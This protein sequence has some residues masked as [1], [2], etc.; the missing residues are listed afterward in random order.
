MEEF[1]IGIEQIGMTLVMIFVCLETYHGTHKAWLLVMPF[2]IVEI[3]SHH[4]YNT[5]I[6]YHDVRF[7]IWCFLGAI[8]FGLSYVCGIKYTVSWF[9]PLKHAACVSEMTTIWLITQKK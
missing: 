5:T 3:L 4:T 2:D 1:Y 7:G 8:I 6:P 9:H